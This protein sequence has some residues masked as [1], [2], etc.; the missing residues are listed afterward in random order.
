MPSLPPLGLDSVVRI[1]ET[2]RPPTGKIP[3]SWKIIRSMTEENVNLDVTIELGRARL[4][5]QSYE[6][7]TA[8]DLLTLEQAAEEPVNVYANGILAAR[9]TL[10]IVDHKFCIR[11][12]ELAAHVNALA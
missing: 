3:H 8:G 11:V 1:K 9:G 4:D 7:L 10:V 2:T 6:K 5:T 12:S